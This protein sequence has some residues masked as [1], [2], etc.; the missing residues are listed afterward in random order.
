[1]AED[2][3]AGAR[4]FPAPKVFFNL[5]VKA[6]L[7]ALPLFLFRESVHWLS[8]WVYWGMYAAWSF[9]NA[10]LLYRQDPALLL[11]RL[12]QAPEVKEPAD[13]LFSLASP[14]LFFIALGVCAQRPCWPGGAAWFTLRLAAFAVIGLAYWLS[15]LALLSNSFALKAVLL[16]PGQTPVSAGP[17]AV[18]RHPLYAALAAFY[19]CTPAALGS[20]A[21]FIP[22]AAAALLV[23][24]RTVFE[25][26][27]LHKGL[28]GYADYSARVRY[29]LFPGLW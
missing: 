23:V 10:L 27:F 4:T 9:I 15:S 26:R 20:T 1:M 13:K 12:M 8:G 3:A 16:Q 11:N 28:P 24:A 5:S 21:G 22:A 25:D 18:V 2:S 14:V 29:R 17:Y 6:L 7:F 19:L